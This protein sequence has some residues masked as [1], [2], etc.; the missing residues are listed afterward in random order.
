MPLSLWYEVPPHVEILLSP[1][2]WTRKKDVVWHDVVVAKR[3]DYGYDPLV[4]MAI[5]PL[6]RSK[7][8]FEFGDHE[9]ILL[10][11]LLR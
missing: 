3:W 6:A 5:V 4:S 11:N 9:L 2:I 8:L 1:A 7:D 10:H